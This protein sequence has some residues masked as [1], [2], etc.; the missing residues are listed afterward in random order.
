MYSS[1]SYAG[2][3]E[4]PPVVIIVRKRLFKYEKD[5]LA[6]WTLESRMQEGNG[7][8]FAAYP[9]TALPGLRSLGFTTQESLMS[10]ALVV[11]SIREPCMLSHTLACN[12]RVMTCVQTPLPVLRPLSVFHSINAGNFWSLTV[13]L[14]DRDQEVSKT[15]NGASTCCVAQPDH[16]KYANG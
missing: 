10:R 12:T 3:V 8:P 11:Q 15:F 4:S 13:P 2:T 5:T 9:A 1:P 14:E 6:P 16:L 7:D